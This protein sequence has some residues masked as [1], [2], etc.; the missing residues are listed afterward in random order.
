MT[1]LDPEQ[2]LEISTATVLDDL[3]ITAPQK[4][5]NGIEDA[6]M[7]WVLPGLPQGMGIINS[8]KSFDLSMFIPNEYYFSRRSLGRDDCLRRFQWR[9][10]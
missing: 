6:G 1:D 2:H 5:V 3:V 10:I 7:M 9:W 4:D 8:A